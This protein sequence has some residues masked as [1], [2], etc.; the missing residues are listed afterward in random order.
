MH[1]LKARWLYLWLVPTFVLLAIFSYW[2]PILSLITAFYH[3]TGGTGI[4]S[5][6]F[7]GLANF[8]YIFSDPTFYLALIHIAILTF[9]PLVLS[10]FV[11]IL[12]AE[13]LFHMKSRWWAGFY[14]FLIMV[15]MVT[16]AI[17]G[18]LVWSFF[19]SPVDGLLNILLGDLGLQQYE[20]AWLANNHYALAALLFMGI[21]FLWGLGA[22]IVLAGLQGVPDSVFEA[23]ALD[24]ATGW[25][26]I[27]QIDLPL[28]S[29]QIRLLI[30]IGIIGGLQNFFQP[31][32]MTQGG[33][34]NA[35]MV[36]GLMMYQWAFD[37]GSGIPQYGLAT[38]MGTLL[39]VGILG[40][41]IGLNRF[42]RSRA[43][44]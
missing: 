29:G 2:P 5:R 10:L 35:T 1:L 31:L 15:P 43:D 25:R 11:N 22:L 26:R 19:Y 23:A 4:G 37:S 16:P 9:V 21:P 13:I 36:P 6:Y 12:I 40:L 8:R 3:D 34:D 28:V 27:R 44:L 38:A 14:R 24:G 18:T 39:F 42:V 17:V 41:T 33:P 32:I 20:H 7:V 30:I